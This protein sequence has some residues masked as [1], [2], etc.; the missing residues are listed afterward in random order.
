MSKITVVGLGYIGLPTSIILAM[1]GH[2]V[3]G[4]DTSQTAID[5]L[6]Q[7]KIHIVEENL[8]EKYEEVFNVNLTISSQLFVSEVYSTFLF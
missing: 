2:R 5:M 8:Q 6:N 4:Y 7:G 1:N 3:F